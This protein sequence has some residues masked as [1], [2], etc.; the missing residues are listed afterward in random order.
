[1]LTRRQRFT[2][3]DI[4]RETRAEC[5][6]TKSCEECRA[7]IKRGLMGK[8]EWE[9]RRLCDACASA[10]RNAAAK[11]RREAKSQALKS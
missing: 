5:A 4:S 1:M 8:K 9:K 11:A 10:A 6:A 3:R 7:A 2:G